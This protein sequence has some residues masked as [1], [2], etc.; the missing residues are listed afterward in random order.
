MG[1]TCDSAWHKVSIQPMLDIKVVI[2]DLKV[3][4]VR[5]V[6]KSA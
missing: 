4:F 1:S 6:F 2:D 5:I 3:S